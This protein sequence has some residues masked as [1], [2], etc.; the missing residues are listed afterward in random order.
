MEI[1]S[2]N[3]LKKIYNIMKD[4][5]LNWQWFRDFLILQYSSTLLLGLH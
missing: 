1:K 5:V 3:L 2:L 4:R